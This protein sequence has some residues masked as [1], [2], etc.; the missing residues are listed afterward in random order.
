MR[1]GVI[2]FTSNAGAWIQIELLVREIRVKADF[3]FPL[4]IRHAFDKHGDFAVL[5]VLDDN[6][7]SERDDE[8]GLQ[9][10]AHL[11]IAGHTV[12]ERAGHVGNGAAKE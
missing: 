5:I 12:A 1:K 2:G 6:G 8:G 10:D 7:L 11:R 9:A 4:L 3:I